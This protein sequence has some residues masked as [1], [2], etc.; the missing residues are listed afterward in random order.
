MT[1]TS[2][3]KKNAKKDFQKIKFKVGKHLPK[4]LNETRATFKAKTLI[5]KQ[6]FQLE[7]DGPVSHRN[8]SWKDLLSHLGHHNQSV[9]M[10]ALT[11]LKEMILGNTDLLKLELGHFL[12]NIC[13]L[14]SDREYNIRETTMQLFKTL[15][16]MPM[17]ANRSMLRP[18]YNLINVHLSLAMT[19]IVDNV[20]YSSLKLLDLLIAHLPELVRTHAYSI[21][22]NFIDQISKAPLKGDRRVLKNDPFKLTSTQAWRQNVL[23]RLHKML[24]IISS[25]PLTHDQVDESSNK[26]STVVHFDS[27]RQCLVTKEIEQAQPM[28]LRIYKKLNSKKNVT[29]IKEFFNVYFK[30]LVPLLIDCWVEAK[31]ENKNIIDNLESLNI[32]NFVLC[33]LNVLLDNLGVGF[34]QL[35]KYIRTKNGTI[36]HVENLFLSNFPYSLAESYDLQ[37]EAKKAGVQTNATTINLLLCKF[38]CSS[39]LELSKDKLVN[40]FDYA[41]GIL[42]GSSKREKNNFQMTDGGGERG[43]STV[44]AISMNELETLLKISESIFMN[45]ARFEIIKPF[46][47]SLVQYFEQASRHSAN[48]W[49]VFEFLCRQFSENSNLSKFNNTF[50]KFYR[51]TYKYCIDYAKD[52]KPKL[53]TLIDWIR[54]LVI[55]KG[56]TQEHVLTILED[57]YI[58]LL[59]AIDFESPQISDS[60]RKRM[61]ELLNWLPK[62]NRYLFTKLAILILSKSLSV[63][64]A[65]KILSILKMKLE[66]NAKTNVFAE[67]DYMMF[68]MQVL[69]GY[70]GFDLTNYA[71]VVN[72]SGRFYIDTNKFKK[73]DLLCPFLEDLISSHDNS[74]SVCETLISTSVP[75]L[76]KLAKVPV[77]TINGTLSILVTYKDLNPDSSCY[78]DIMALMTST[79]VWSCTTSKIIREGMRTIDDQVESDLNITEKLLDKIMLVYDKHPAFLVESVPLIVSCFKT[80]NIEDVKSMAIVLTHLIRAQPATLREALPALYDVLGLYQELENSQYLWWHDFANSVKYI[81]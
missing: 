61:L 57:E 22:Q 64:N 65:N 18:F 76:L 69:N 73:H 38:C 60:S 78:N 43:F 75:T 21:F 33:I 45:F 42:A 14:F 9:R 35:A 3:A 37:N 17:F 20:Q 34:G 41:L 56:K 52:K 59:N 58:N 66:N 67:A 47:V 6:Q 79:L 4:N 48:K 40:L 16:D 23:N 62:I 5:I 1:K 44:S 10:D 28:S 72:D 7:K 46:L 31:P 55:A 49:A 15:I 71:Y 80:N 24:L 36:E 81:V 70:S 39:I 51:K 12:E 29:E 13:P 2:A 26:E 19:H 25:D 8:L 63:V 30:I 50:V 54:R 32:M 27:V 74:D 77:T 11:S 68:L 53:D